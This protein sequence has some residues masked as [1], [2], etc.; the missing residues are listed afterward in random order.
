MI[1]K[2]RSLFF[3]FLGV[4]HERELLLGGRQFLAELDF[5]PGLLFGQILAG[6]V[7]DFFDL[8]PCL[9]KIFL[10]GFQHPPQLLGVAIP[11]QVVGHGLL[12]EVVCHGRADDFVCHEIVD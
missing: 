7:F 4:H 1:I 9:C 12:A 10:Q 3:L 6:G 11:V 5:H 8:S 2:V